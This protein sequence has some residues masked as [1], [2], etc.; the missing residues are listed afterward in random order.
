MTSD[1]KVGLLLGLVFIVV[2]AFLINGLPSLLSSG[3]SNMAVDPTV[4][5]YPGSL[6]LIDKAEDA[7]IKANEI[8]PLVFKQRDLKIDSP[9]NND[10][11]F[12]GAKGI[13]KEGNKN[14]SDK[15]PPVSTKKFYTVKSGDSLGK[16]AIKVYGKE[17]GNKQATVDLIFQANLNLLSFP[18][19]IDVGQKLIMPFF[20]RDEKLAEKNGRATVRRSLSSEEEKLLKS[21]VFEKVGKAFKEVFAKKT[22]SSS[23]SVYVVKDGDSL[24]DISVKWLGKGSRYRE[25]VKLNNSILKGAND[26]APNMKL[27]IPQK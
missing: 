10:P 6:G 5:V 12:G 26:L 11:R 23:L 13:A 25:I 19:D 3:P 15:K 18:D 1:A 20:G 16:I 4:R 8:D 24:W 17:L 2:I 7:V 21:G 9:G 27:K 14:S 22:N